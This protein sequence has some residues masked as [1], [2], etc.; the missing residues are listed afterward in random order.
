MRLASTAAAARFLGILPIANIASSL[1]FATSS[2]TL[3]AGTPARL[4]SSA[5][6]SVKFCATSSLGAPISINLTKAP[7]AAS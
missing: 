6:A 1:A 7:A 2:I 4:L 3:P 5:V